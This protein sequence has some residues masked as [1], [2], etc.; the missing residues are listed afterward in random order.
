[1]DLATETS[2]TPVATG[3]R[4]EMPM[5]DAEFDSL[6]GSAEFQVRSVLVTTF[7]HL[8]RSVEL[9]YAH[10]PPKRFCATTTVWTGEN[11][12]MRV[13]SAALALT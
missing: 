7:G 12:H 9:P 3:T 10:S 11:R 6:L 5:S 1:M 4:S 13:V 2:L 8:E